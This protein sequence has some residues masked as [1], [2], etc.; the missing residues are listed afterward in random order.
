M[1]LNYIRF[2]QDEA[3]NAIVKDSDDL[4]YYGATNKWPNTV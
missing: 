1:K 2:L 4:D 3:K